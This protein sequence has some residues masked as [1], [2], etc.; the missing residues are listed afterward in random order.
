MIPFLC[1]REKS[2][3]FLG[4]T[5]AYCPPRLLLES[6]SVPKIMTSTASGSGKIDID[7]SLS[8]TYENKSLFKQINA[9]FSNFLKPAPRTKYMF[10]FQ[11]ALCILSN[12]TLLTMLFPIPGG[13][14]L[15]KRRTNLNQHLT[16]THQLLFMAKREWRLGGTYLK[17]CCNSQ[18]NDILCIS[19][20]MQFVSIRQ[21]KLKGPNKLDRWL[22][23]T[24]RLRRFSSG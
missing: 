6:F 9:D 11:S 15:A 21:T 22:R 10:H 20:S 19:G 3:T 8:F 18:Q 12:E 24:R 13:I 16:E 5:V 1:D 2:R 23:S 14:L 17:P 7:I 4:R